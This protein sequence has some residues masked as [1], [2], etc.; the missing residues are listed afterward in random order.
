MMD[1]VIVRYRLPLPP[2]FNR[3]PAWTTLHVREHT[4]DEQVIEEVFVQDV[5]R[6]RDL[7]LANRPNPVT[8]D[9][10]PL[11]PLIIDVG[12]CTGIFTALACQAFPTAELIAVEPD[13]ANF[14]LL[15]VNTQPWNDRITR[16]R[17]IVGAANGRA[18]LEGSHGTAHVDTNPDEPRD[19]QTVDQVTLPGMIVDRV[20][21]LKMDIEGG[22]YDAFD[23]CPTEKIALIDYIAMEWHGTREAPWVA[24]APERYGRLVA[25]LAH[26]HAVQMFGDPDAGGMLFAH[27]YDL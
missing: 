1:D 12:A 8:V 19:G 11:G 3:P 9:P 25:K 23:A 26:T 18:L 2:G 15:T 20:A 17:A 14:G 27:R 7:T 16:V 21:L 24:G 6:L 4:S 22:E 5:Y 10:N 13:L